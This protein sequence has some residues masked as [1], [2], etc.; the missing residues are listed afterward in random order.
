M[1]SLSLCSQKL[2]AKLKKI[3]KKQFRTHIFGMCLNLQFLLCRQ[4]TKSD[5]NEQAKKI[6]FMKCDKITFPFFSFS[7]FSFCGFAWNEC[8]EINRYLCKF[9]ATLFQVFGIFKAI[10]SSTV[11]KNK[12]SARIFCRSRPVITFDIFFDTDIFILHEPHRTFTLVVQY[13]WNLE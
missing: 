10:N 9:M 5:R 12:R 7:P 2:S 3:K 4:H 11:R 1:V 13:S 6:N 8:V